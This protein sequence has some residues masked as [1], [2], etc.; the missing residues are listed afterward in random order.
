MTL[1]LSRA[2]RISRRSRLDLPRAGEPPPSRELQCG[3]RWANPYAA[4]DALH[5]PSPGMTW[6]RAGFRTCTVPNRTRADRPHPGPSGHATPRPPSTR[7]TSCLIRSSSR[8][9]I[10]APSSGHGARDD[11]LGCPSF[12]PFPTRPVVR[13]VVVGPKGDGMGGGHAH[14][15]V[16]DGAGHRVWSRHRAAE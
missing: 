5:T 12:R 1:S 6:I 9:P 16:V 14:Y 2:S 7:A 8:D 10:V 11:P 3:G 13:K 15:V 4:S